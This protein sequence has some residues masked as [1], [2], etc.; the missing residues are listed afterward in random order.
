MGLAD[1]QPRPNPL[2]ESRYQP[3]GVVDIGSN[4]VRLVIYEGPWRHAVP[5]HNEKAICA[6]GRNMVS[7]GQLDESGLVGKL[8]A[9]R[10]FAF[11]D[12]HN[13]MTRAWR[14]RRTRCRQWPRLRHAEKV[15]GRPVRIPRAMRRRIAAEGTLAG[16]RRRWVVADL[17]GGA[18]TGHGKDRKT[19]TAA[20]LPSGR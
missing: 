9:G 19:G 7:S 5:L 11:C 10:G 13:V 3:I 15:L 20:T 16:I 1:L 14:L 12:G 4:S 6:I 2:N 17:G 8:E 18:R